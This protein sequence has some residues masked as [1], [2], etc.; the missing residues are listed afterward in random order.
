M[1]RIDQVLSDFMDAWGAG[2][3]PRVDDYL[4]AVEPGERDELAERLQEWLALAPSPRHDEETLAAI[5]AEP[6]L[7]RALAEIEADPGW[8]PSL[9]ERAGLGLREL[10]ARV[11]A[12]FGL[13]GEEARAEALLGRLERGELDP[14]RA[15][16][17]LLDV[18]GAALG[19]PAASLARARGA[20]PA[21]A[22]ALFRADDAA[23]ERFAEELDA[24]S[25][26]ATAPAPE[27][28]DALERLF[29]GGP[30]A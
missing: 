19:V 24:L 11:T 7:A 16:R 23:A 30:D 13:R 21:A 27:P 29:C 8:L 22:A 20:R 17:R 26:A 1:S 18:L 9:R 14:A 10:A 15:S 25:R 2:R 5:R 4:A 28:M 6:A 3:R 12:A